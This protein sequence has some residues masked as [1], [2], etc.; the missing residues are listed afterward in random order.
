MRGSM[1]LNPCYNGNKLEREMPK[2]K[3]HIV[4]FGF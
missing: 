2:G 1:G 3:Y 4:G